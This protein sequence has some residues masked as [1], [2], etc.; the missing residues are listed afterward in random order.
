M[1]WEE[2][3]S[4]ALKLSVQQRVALAKELLASLDEL[5]DQEIEALWIEEAQRRDAELADAARGIPAGDV[6]AR[7]RAR[8][9]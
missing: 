5:T 6:L 7:A 9:K 4:E 2:L 1:S 8:L 3:K